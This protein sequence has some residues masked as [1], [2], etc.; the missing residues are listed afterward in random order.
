MHCSL[1]FLKCFNLCNSILFLCTCIRMT[2]KVKLKL[3][4]RHCSGLYTYCSAHLEQ[5]LWSCQSRTVQTEEHC[6]FSAFSKFD[7]N[8]FGDVKVVSSASFL[9]RSPTMLSLQKL[10]SEYLNTNCYSWITIL[11][12]I[13]TCIYQVHLPSVPNFSALHSVCNNTH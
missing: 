4:L 13:N 6:L 11:E 5:G 10:L 9:L 2:I 7:T 1:F 12:T 8:D 3:K